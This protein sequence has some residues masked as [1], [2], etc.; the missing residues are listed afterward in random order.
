MPYDLVVKEA[1]RWLRYA[2]EDFDT[3]VILREEGVPRNACLLAQQSA[4][5]AIKTIFVLANQ[6]YSEKSQFGPLEKPTFRGV[7]Y[8]D[9]DR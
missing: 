2:R 3:A 8:K 1:A 4:E 7:G 6:T 5:K 9:S